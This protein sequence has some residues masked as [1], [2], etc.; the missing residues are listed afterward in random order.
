MKWNAGKY[1][2]EKKNQIT[3]IKSFFESRK[4]QRKFCN[5]EK[6]QK[7]TTLISEIFNL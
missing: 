5:F 6:T 4:N 1:G 3:C 7:I 2:N